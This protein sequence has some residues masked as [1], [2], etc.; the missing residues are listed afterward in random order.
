[1]WKELGV[2]LLE[3]FLIHYTTGTLLQRGEVQLG[4]RVRT[5]HP[6]QVTLKCDKLIKAEVPIRLKLTAVASCDH[7]SVVSLLS[8]V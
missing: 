7:Q 8:Q 5:Q 1:M 4:D 3:G 6:T 2:D